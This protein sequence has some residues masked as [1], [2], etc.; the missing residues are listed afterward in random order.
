MP[1]QIPRDSRPD[2]NQ[3]C[4]GFHTTRWSVVLVAGSQ[5][6]ENSGEALTELCQAYWYPLYAF[7]RR[8]GQSVHDAQDVTQGFFVHMLERESF[9]T[10]DPDRGRF[11]SFLLGAFKRFMISEKRRGAAQKRGGGIEFVPFGGG[12][13]E[14]RYQIES[15]HDLTPERLYQRSWVEALLERVRE[16]LAGDYQKAGKD[17]LYGVLRPFLLGSTNSGTYDDVAAEIGM[18]RAAVAMSVHRMRRRFGE[19]LREEIAH[20][21]DGQDEVDDELRFLLSIMAA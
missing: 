1:P 19:L 14:G 12:E 15:S 10:A 9:Q 11:R 7:A 2:F 16:N 3:E 20:T 21:V 4:A 13:L 18:S 6:C 5:R 17:S 8:S